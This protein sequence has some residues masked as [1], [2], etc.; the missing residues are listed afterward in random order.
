LPQRVYAIKSKFDI[1]VQGLDLGAESNGKSNEND[2]ILQQLP[3]LQIEKLLI[4]DTE[5]RIVEYIKSISKMTLPKIEA[6]IS[7]ATF[8]LDFLVEQVRAEPGSYSSEDYR[9]I[10]HDILI[11]KVRIAILKGEIVRRSSN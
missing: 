6:E 11:R 8:D 10:S 1:C 7:E 5:K 4:N 9:K 2:A 3:F